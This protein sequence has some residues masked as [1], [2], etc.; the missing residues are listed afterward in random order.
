MIKSFII[1]GYYKNYFK[2]MDLY[3]KKVIYKIEK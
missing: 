3:K 1:L 2:K